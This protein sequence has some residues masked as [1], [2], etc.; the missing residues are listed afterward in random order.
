MAQDAVNQSA[1]LVMTTPR[2]ARALGVPPEKWVY[3]HGHAEVKDTLVS[4]RPD[5]SRSDAIDLA[6]GQAL[7]TS[8]PGSGGLAASDIAHYDIYSCFPIVI[9]L[10]AEYLGLDPLVE[11]LTVTGGLPFF[12]GPGNN[13]STHAIAAMVQTLRKDRGSYGLVL[14]NG[15]FMSKEAAGVFSTTGPKSWEP[16]SNATIQQKIADRPDIAL[17]DGNC[18]AVIEGY[19]VIH[20]KNGPSGAYVIARNDGGRI[21]ARIDLNDACAAAL[22]VGSENLVGCNVVVA[23]R[24]GANFVVGPAAG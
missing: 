13:Y 18:D 4:Q 23:H 2:K 8:G 21:I 10:A 7:A 17:I 24:D 6:L 22:L 1:A 16:C 9:M 11:R 19:T 20:G 3:L 5:L 12:G 15:G 14:A